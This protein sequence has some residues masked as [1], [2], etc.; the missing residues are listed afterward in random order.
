MTE[1][2]SQPQPFQAEV[3]RLLE[4]VVHALY[5]QKEIFLRELISNAADACDRLRYLAITKPELAPKKYAIHLIADKAKKI[6]TISDNGIGMSRDEM[7]GNLGTIARSG[8]KAFLEQLSGDAKKDMNLIG[9]FGVGFY[10]AFMVAD[11]VEVISR[12]ADAAE[13]F[14]WTSDGKGTFTLEPAEKN[15][16]GTDVTLHLKDEADE[17]LE[18]ERLKYIVR[19]YS[20]HIPVPVFFGE[21]ESAQL[22]RATSLWMRPKAEIKPEEYKEFYHH[23]A[24]AFDEPQI[25]IHWRAEGALEYTGLL[26]VPTQKPYD[27]FDPRRLSRVKLYVKRVFITE[28]AEG[29]IPPYLRFLR[30]VIDSED[31]PLNISR[32]MLQHNPVLAR[33]KAGIT[34]RVLGELHKL[35]EDKEAYASFWE[36]YGPIIKEGLYEDG[37]FRDDLLKLFRANSTRGEG[38]TTLDEYISRMP[39]GQKAIYYITGENAAML[40][41]SPQLE[42]FRARNIEVLLLSDAIDDFWLPMVGAYKDKQLVSATRGE[43]KLDEIKKID[44]PEAAAPTPQTEKLIAALKE[45]YG[46]AVAGVRA[47]ARLTESPVCLVAGE[48]EVDMHLEKLLRQNKTLGFA[49]KRVLEINPAHSLMARMATLAEAGN[50]EPLADLAWLLLDQARLLE[51]EPLADPQAFSQRLTRLA[52]KAVA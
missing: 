45:I 48:G 44:Q 39:E 46:E 43:V 52:E 23:V 9:Q 6:L 50:K 16:P 49:P 3:S 22:N 42:G 35:S 2:S 47:S 36:T 18:E 29:L 37:D 38:L 12:R 8:T 34:R 28:D 25:T 10:S 30:G 1:P 31:L 20:D 40:A 27:L 26:F 21:D 11:K 32:E 51:G 14:R 17:Y 15:L 13:A 19:E 7:A 5:S 4:I 24:H 33:M 41:A